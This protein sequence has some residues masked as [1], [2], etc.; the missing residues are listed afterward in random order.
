LVAVAAWGVFIVL[1]SA[2]PV[3]GGVFTWQQAVRMALNQWLPW[4][5]LSPLIFWFTLRLPI[6]RNGW[7]WRIS[8]HLIVGVMSVVACAGL[9][10]YI[11]APYLP[12]FGRDAR[13][14]VNRPLPSG[15]PPFGQSR[16]PL[17]HG[18]PPPPHF[19]D[20]RPPLLVRA[21]FNVPIYLTIVSLCHTIAYFRRSQQRGRRTL[22][23]ETLLGQARLQALRMQLH[24]HF[25]FNTLN[26]ISTLVNSN[27]GAARE[28]IGSLGQMLRLSL[29]SES[30]AEVALEQ[31]LKFLD[32]YLEIQQVR[33]GD[34]LKV[35]RNIAPDTGNAL[36]PTFILQPLVENAI[37]HGIEPGLSPGTIEISAWR[38]ADRLMISLRDTGVGLTNDIAKT[39]T[40]NGIGIA[41]TKARLQSLYPGQ[42]RFSVR[43]ASGGGCV[44]ELE[45][46][47]HTKPISVS[48][49]F[50]EW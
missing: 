14:F 13:E 2:M 10:D 46:P 17:P 22:E 29:D 33:F 28:M 38:A 50:E 40:Q 12:P 34:R 1:V 15:N 9:S 25:L 27:P 3:L 23:L 11:I 4:M 41:N 31:E 5:V 18:E 19:H 44:A 32:C 26:T 21:Q 39:S 7:A 42:H 48:G 36:V 16:N 47:F 45:M 6:E 8:A 43:N 30:K 35:K 49:V 24:P 37:R 20:N